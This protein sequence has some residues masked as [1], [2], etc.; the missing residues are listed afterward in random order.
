M[1][2]Y[3]KRDK[4]NEH[5]RYV[6]YDELFKELYTVLG[7]HS[8][9]GERMYIQYS[10]NCIAKIRITSLALLRSC[11]VTTNDENFR[12]VI[13]NT[14]D[15]IAI[16]YHGVAYHIRGDVLLKSYDILDVD[17]TLIACVQKR[18]NT[19]SEVLEINVNNSK[20][21]LSCIASALC[22][23]TICTNDALLLQT[24]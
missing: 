10:D 4:S 2:I 21:E 16:N 9:S 18:F 13:T 12:I 19:N 5:C 1:K 17:N 8:S 14:K 3:L 20:H 11:H 7:K 23:N 22:L 6:V 24:T 15:K